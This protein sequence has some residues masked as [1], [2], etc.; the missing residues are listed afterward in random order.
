MLTA[1]PPLCPFQKRSAAPPVNA[2]EQEQPDHVNEVPVPGCRLEAEMM[3]RR[4]VA[5]PAAEPAD[6]EE[7]GADD[8][9]EAVEAGRQIEGRSV[10]AV[11]ETEGSVAVLISLQNGEK[12]TEQNGKTEAELELVPLVLDQGVVCPGHRA[13]GQQTPS[14]SVTPE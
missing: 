8:H 2:D 9:V 12:R 1:F 7:G 11:G 3:I 5:G 10:D 6:T 4:E 13:A 14:A